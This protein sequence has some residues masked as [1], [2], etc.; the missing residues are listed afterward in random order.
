[1]NQSDMLQ[2]AG[3][4]AKLLI[5][6]GIR[7][8]KDFIDTG[9]EI[10]K[11]AYNKTYDFLY[12]EFES[13]LFFKAKVPKAAEY[14]EVVMPYLLPDRPVMTAR[15]RPH[16]MDDHWTMK[17]LT[18][19]SQYIDYAQIEGELYQH[20]RR[21]TN[22]ALL[23]GR[24]VLWTGYNAR[25]GIIQ[26]TFGDV[27]DLVTDPDARSKEERNWICRLR[28]KPRWEW[29][30][31]YKQARQAI[32]D[33]PV[34][35]GRK[36]RRHSSDDKMNEPV[37]LQ[38]FYC[39]TG[40]HNYSSALAQLMKEAQDQSREAEVTLDDSP[41][42]YV[43]CDG[44]VIH[45]D[46]WEIPFFMDD[47]WPCEE[48]DFR[49]K[50][51][52][53]WPPAPLEAGLGY[54]QAMNWA[55]TLTLSRMR[56]TERLT[57]AVLDNGQTDLDDKKIMELL[58][59]D[60]M[61]VVKIRSMDNQN[62]SEL[63]QQFSL[64][65]HIDNLVN[66]Q[67]HLGQAFAYAVGL[68]DVL[69]AGSA[70]TQSRSATDAQMKEERSRSR[71][72]DMKTLT[73]R[74]LSRVYRKTLFAARFIHDQGDIQKMFGKQA[75]QVWGTLAPPEAVEQQQQARQQQKQMMLQ[76]VQQMLQS[77]PPG[78]PPPPD[79]PTSLDE[80][81]EALGPPELVSMDGWI[82]EA[83]REVEAGTMRR[84]THEQQ[85]ENLNVGLNQLGPAVG[86]HPAG[87]GFLAALA[88]EFAEVNRF[89][90][91]LTQA[92]KQFQETVLNPPT[93][94]PGVGAPPDGGEE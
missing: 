88:V 13:E 76:Q 47:F 91:R 70:D 45:I 68:Y 24:G 82:N 5:D 93:P 4:I 32:W 43:V 65:P 86:S 18:L 17:R 28:V 22:Q 26:N 81:D 25:K 55:M 69:Y 56:L 16:V 64:D 6:A 8:R 33:A 51:G 72:N 48:L 59:G 49:E 74:F 75:S 20:L 38:F 50:P 71:I 30:R 85:V 58:Q 23:Y 77:L 57:V 3:K 35:G 9:E 27:R 15:P 41:K 39:R 40:L 84:V 14:L 44:K 46:T 92:A 54:I 60:Q 19:E 63:I 11:Y 78:T 61:D 10:E 52:C 89:S 87:V 34:K 37:E 73:E 31:R 2:Q 66:L 79:V 53:T 21:A 67:S 94:P 1:M 36:G 7:D 62:I 83:D 80:V 42:L 12:Q 90:P 29:M